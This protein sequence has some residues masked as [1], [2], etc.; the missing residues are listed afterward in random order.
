[1]AEGKEETWKVIFWERQIEEDA[2][3]CAHTETATMDCFIL[4][5][6]KKVPLG[7]EIFD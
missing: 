5:C 1:M 2:G 4:C 7:L 6:C 3:H